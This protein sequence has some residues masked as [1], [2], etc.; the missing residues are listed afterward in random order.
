MSIVV[1]KNSKVLV[2]GF[3]GSEGTFHSEQMIEYGKKYPE[4]SFKTHKG[5]GTK[6]HYFA[7]NEHGVCDIHRKTWIK[8]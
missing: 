1:N 2:Q 6:A 4:Y 3:T 5:Y 7:I 8:S